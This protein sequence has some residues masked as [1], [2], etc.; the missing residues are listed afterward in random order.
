M[1]K[2]QKPVSWKDQKGM[3]ERARK[4]LRSTPRQLNEREATLK[5]KW[6]LQG[7]TA[8]IFVDKRS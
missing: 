7:T 8:D 2:Y 1:K 5:N 3:K 6:I 4:Q